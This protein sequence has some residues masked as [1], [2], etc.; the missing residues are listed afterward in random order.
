M[1]PKAGFTPTTWAMLDRNLSG[2][3]ALL[4]MRLRRLSDDKESDGTIEQ[5]DVDALVAYHKLSRRRMANS[6]GE[7]VSL[8]FLDDLGDGVYQ[9]TEFLTVCRSKDQRVERRRQWQEYQQGKRNHPT[10]SSDPSISTADTPETPQSVSDSPSLAPSLTPAPAPDELPPPAIAQTNGT[11]AYPP[12]EIAS[13]MLRRLWEGNAKRASTPSEISHIK[14]WLTM[15]DLG[16]NQVANVMTRVVEREKP[17]GTVIGHPSY[18]DAAIREASETAK[19]PRAPGVVHV[20]GEPLAP[21]IPR[22]YDSHG[23]PDP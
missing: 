7:L 11:A 18:F 19:P 17:R 8:G 23:N 3:A 9:D 15:Y 16:G 6:I 5:R 14:W 10:P 1:S 13:T 4:L 12:S 20:I 22:G 2:D 21:V